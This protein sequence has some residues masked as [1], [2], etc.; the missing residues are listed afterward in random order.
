MHGDFYQ[1]V[2]AIA[3]VLMHAGAFSAQD[4]HGG[5]DV[6]DVSVAFFGALIHAV[7]PVAFFFQV[8]ERAIEISDA[9]DGE[10][11]EG[12]G[13]GLGHGIGEA[14]G[15]ALRDENAGGAGGIGGTHDGPEVVWIFDTIGGDDEGPE[16]DFVELGIA[17]GGGDG[18]DT[19]VGGGT[20][21]TIQDGARLEAYGDTALPREVD[22]R[23]D[24]DAAGPFGNQD[25]I[26]LA[27]AFESF[28]NRVDAGENIF[29]ENVFIRG[30]Y[31]SVSP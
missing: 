4:E 17:M 15:A 13:G 24:A 21:G 16:R 2:A 25:A 19:L 18:D 22:E 8:L 29:C 9:D 5:R 26:H 31:L 23:L 30:H 28:Q 1:K 3:R 7:D 11:L 14:D 12:T 6:C 27:A 10:V 20:G